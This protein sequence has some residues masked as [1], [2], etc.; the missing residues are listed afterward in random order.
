VVSAI[1]EMD[2][3]SLVISLEA[4]F[5]G[6]GDIAAP[7]LS[8]SLQIG[9]DGIG[10]MSAPI[11]TTIVESGA[12]AVSDMSA[13]Q[14]VVVVSGSFTGVGELG[15]PE[16]IEAVSAPV[17]DSYSTGINTSTFSKPAG[18]VEGDLM[19]AALIAHFS[20]TATLT[21][22]SG[23]TAIGSTEQKT[24]AT[25]IAILWCR[26]VAGASEP[27]SYTWSRSAGSYPMAVATRITGANA[28]SPIDGRNVA[29]WANTGTPRTINSLDVSDDSS[30]VLVYSAGVGY[31]PTSVPAGMS[32]VAII[33][34]THAL[35]E[36][37][38]NAGATGVL[39]HT[40]V[41]NDANGAWLTSMI[42]IRP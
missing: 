38:F 21:P 19:V 28:V 5:S 42:S 37:V 20:A 22:P 1:G 30:L 18:V 35:F 27:A 15:E 16:L 34:T 8:M 29:D 25:E 33:D 14:R 36:G 9:A 26:K 4:S 3:P 10:E 2:A 40:A 17:L 39:S 41:E 11:R 7:V 32:Q 6:T 23:W 31:E 24:T 12:E 13:P